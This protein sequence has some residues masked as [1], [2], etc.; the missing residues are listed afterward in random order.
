MLMIE[1]LTP[2]NKVKGYIDGTRYLDA[3][4]R[5]RA[6]FSGN[7]YKETQRNTE[8]WIYSDSGPIEKFG[9]NWKPGAKLT[10]M[11]IC[12]PNKIYLL[13]IKK[14][15]KLEK[16]VKEGSLPAEV[17][18]KFVQRYLRDFQS[19]KGIEKEIIKILQK[20]ITADMYTAQVPELTDLPQFQEVIGVQF[21]FSTDK[22]QILDYKQRPVLILKGSDAELVQLG[23]KDLFGI[24]AQYLE[25]LL[26]SKLTALSSGSIGSS[27]FPPILGY[28][29]GLAICCVCCGFLF[30]LLFTGVFDQALV[31][32]V[33]FNAAYWQVFLNGG[34][35]GGAGLGVIVYILALAKLA[36]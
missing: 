25:L 12:R 9:E 30:N 16:L 36:L 5:V 8:N 7:C 22:T 14:L 1:I 3:K 27:G 10:E 24:A 28:V 6:N 26:L 2:K 31:Q 13:S 20:W 17:F 21:Q 11:V 33:G 18:K 23:T 29:I 34:F 32:S 4:Q 19:Y 35:W 15:K